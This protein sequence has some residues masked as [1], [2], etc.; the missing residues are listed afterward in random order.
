[1]SKSSSTNEKLLYGTL[2]HVTMILSEMQEGRHYTA[3]DLSATVSHCRD[4]LESA[5]PSLPAPT[6]THPFPR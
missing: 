4:V 2:A 1:M 6:L 3:A 5:R